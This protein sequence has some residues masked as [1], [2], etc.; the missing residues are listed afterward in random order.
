LLKAALAL[1]AIAAGV[2]VLDSEGN[3]HTLPRMA[4]RHAHAWLLITFPVWVVVAN[5]TT[6]LAIFAGWLGLVLLTPLS[7]IFL[8]RPAEKRLALNAAEKGESLVLYLRPFALDSA[9]RELQKIVGKEVSAFDPRDAGWRYTLNPIAIGDRDRGEIPKLATTEESWW[10][11]LTRLAEA[12]EVIIVVPFIQFSA[13]QRGLVRELLHVLAHHRQKVVL[14]M[15]PARILSRIGHGA[16][17]A[18]LWHAL[19]TQL[20][21][22]GIDIELPPYDP[23]GSIFQVQAI[24]SPLRFASSSIRGILDAMTSTRRM[25]VKSLHDEYEE[26]FTRLNGMTRAQYDAMPGKK[27]PPILP[28]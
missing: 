10:N 1:V 14:I 17:A 3:P 15:P 6:F 19:Q 12:A 5:L 26:E 25:E 13:G 4:R 21:Q 24:K 20:H 11:E 7:I 9:T 27:L 2:L 16:D 23:A 28:R 18:A 22:N 8:E